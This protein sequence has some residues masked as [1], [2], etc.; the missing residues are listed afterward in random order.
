VSKTAPGPRA[1][2]ARPPVPRPLG[3]YSAL[4]ILW[5]SPVLVEFSTLPSPG[6]D[7]PSTTEDDW[8]FLIARLS[9]T[10]RGLWLWIGITG[11]IGKTHSIPL[12]AG[13]QETAQAIRPAKMR[14]DWTAQKALAAKAGVGI[15]PPGGQRF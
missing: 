13:G 10:S 5:S 14:R 2:A 4:L 8:P 1:L 7:F 12:P 9:A 11:A 15:H 3:L 6:V